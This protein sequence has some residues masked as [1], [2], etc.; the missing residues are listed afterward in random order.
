MVSGD[1]VT[2]TLTG[3]A[4]WGFRLTGGGALPLEISKIRKKSQAHAQGLREG[5]AVVSINGIPVHDRTHDQALDLID[6]AGDTLTLQIYRGEADDLGQ[7]LASNKPAPTLAPFLPPG[8]VKERSPTMTSSASSVATY[9]DGSTQRRVTQDI[10]VEQ[11]VGLRK[12]TFVRREETT[13][14]STTTSGGGE[15]KVVDGEVIIPVDTIITCDSFNGGMSVETSSTTQRKTSEAVIQLQRPGATTLATTS[16]RPSPA[17]SPK[18][19]PV[20]SSSP[21]VVPK[22]TFKAV[23]PKTPPPV[24]PK[25]SV[26]P[27]VP[28]KPSFKAAPP[29]GAPV[30]SPGKFQVSAAAMFTPSTQT[31]YLQVEQ[32][33]QSS[34]PTVHRQVYS[35]SVPKPYSP[36]GQRPYSPAGQPSPAPFSPLSVSSPLSPAT[37]SQSF[38][39]SSLGSGPMF[40]VRNNLGKGKTLWQPN[41]WLPGQE[42]NQQQSQPKNQQQQQQQQ[43][44][45]DRPSENVEVPPRMSVKERQQML[46]NQTA[47]NKHSL[48]ARQMEPAIFQLQSPPEDEPFINSHILHVFGPPVE[49]TP[50]GPRR[51]SAGEELALVRTDSVESVPSSPGSSLIRR[52]KKLYSDSAFYEDPEHKYPTIQEQMKLCRIISQS[53]TSAANRK[54]RGAKMFARRKRKSSRWV[55]EGHSEWSSSAGDVAN[56]DELDSELSPDEG[57]NKVLFTFRIPSVKHRVSSPESNT[58]MSLK[59]DEFERL[60]LQAAKCDHTA[61][62]P[63]TCFD[64]AADLKA[65]KGRAGRLFERRKN[66][67]DKFIIDETNARSPG[68]R[69]PRLEDLLKT[70]LKSQLSPWE[71]AQSDDAGR[72]DAAFDHLT[73][74]E[75]MQKLNQ[76]LKY[77]PPKAAVPDL[78][79]T[80]Y[81]GPHTDLRSDTQPH[82]LRDVTSTEWQGVGRVEPTA[83][84]VYQRQLL[85]PTSCHSQPLV[86]PAPFSIQKH[87]GRRSSLVT[88]TPAPRPGKGDNLK[89]TPSRVPHPCRRH[90]LPVTLRLPP[91]PPR[92]ICTPPISC[93][94]R[95]CKGERGWA[96][97]LPVS[98][99]QSDSYHVLGCGQGRSLASYCP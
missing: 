70:P 92:L 77:K 28:P 98:S 8:T 85:H 69:T 14:V 53:L 83:A 88:T 13:S 60:R 81:T 73:D 86:P 90:G 22:P 4:P 29:P 95:I 58:K 62:S 63:G 71:A 31:P 26:A 97:A 7:L 65:S 87:K 40:N 79:P 82:L 3:G 37:P 43:Q 75:R 51:D 24:A 21:L 48:S 38:S 36:S 80:P 76:M 2:V 66:R 39:P 54:A 57:G 6:H 34:L 42:P 45:R 94:P 50:W 41:M 18:P 12:Q 68:P 25:P 30:F 9:D 96:G 1:N 17:V 23:A 46:L 5:D 56:L 47:V 55:H 59:K 16:P 91:S 35:P 99:T 10:F 27:Q 15:I 78:A 67:A 84:L 61:V 11:D 93:P 64:I 44:Q 89:E 19:E 52:K 20:K 49:I 32:Q 74:V 72:V 33:Q